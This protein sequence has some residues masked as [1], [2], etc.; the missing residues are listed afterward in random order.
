MQH[1]AV[2]GSKAAIV[3][4]LALLLL[5]QVVLIPLQA[6][7]TVQM[8]PEV[9]YLRIP[10]IVGCIAIVACVQFA[11]ICVW[12]LLSMVA[13]GSIFQPSAFRVVNTIIGCIIAATCLL[14]AAFVILTVANAM[15][16]GVVIM[17]VMGITGGAGLALLLVVMRGLLR[18]ATG[19]DQDLAEVI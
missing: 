1:A 15:P 9:E 5:A 4:I 13:K 7:Q 2:A 10:G 14:V 12:S 11:L 8:F 19:L 18:K 16:P 3:V 6:A 17:L